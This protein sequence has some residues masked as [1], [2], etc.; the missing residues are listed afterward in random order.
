MKLTPAEQQ[1]LS[2]LL[3]RPINDSNAHALLTATIQELQAAAK[4]QR[5]QLSIDLDGLA[6][7]T[8]DLS[9]ADIARIKVQVRELCRAAAG[10]A[11]HPGHRDPDLDTRA[12][13]IYTTS[14]RRDDL[15]KRAAAA[16]GAAGAE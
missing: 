9:A 7:D 12:A 4:Q 13:A 6:A 16:Y 10:R 15:D 5:K 2:R 14:D 11:Q 8:F 1:S 3:D